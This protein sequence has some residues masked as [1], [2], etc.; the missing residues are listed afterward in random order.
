MVIAL[1]SL[2]VRGS[3]DSPDARR[4]RLL[5]ES[6]PLGKY[7]RYGDQ[8]AAAARSILR[9]RIFRSSSFMP[10]QIPWDSRVDRA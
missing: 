6:P 1:A 4:G 8:L 5:V 2:V 10:P 3:H 7:A 9:S